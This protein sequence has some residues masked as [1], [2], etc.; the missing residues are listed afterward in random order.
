MIKMEIQLFMNWV[1]TLTSIFC[2]RINKT[3]TIIEHFL[4]FA[5]MFLQP[6]QCYL[7]GIFEH[8]LPF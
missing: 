1:F 6:N 3:E 8:W 7:N 5:E 4:L 2:K